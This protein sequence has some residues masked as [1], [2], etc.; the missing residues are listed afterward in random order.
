MMERV[1]EKLDQMD[2][3]FFSLSLHLRDLKDGPETY[4]VI[5]YTMD[6]YVG[7]LIF[8]TV[9]EIDGVIMSHSMHWEV[10]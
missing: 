7:C 2:S 6:R 4:D 10:Q 3:L 1:H 8:N 9:K 5:P